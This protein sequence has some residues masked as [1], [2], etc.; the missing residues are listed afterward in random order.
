MIRADAFIPRLCKL[1]QQQDY[2]LKRSLNLFIDNIV[3]HHVYVPSN[4]E[5]FAQELLTSPDHYIN[6]AYYVAREMLGNRTRSYSYATDFSGQIE[7]VD[8]SMLQQFIEQFRTG[9]SNAQRV[10]PDTIRL[11]CPAQAMVLMM[12]QVHRGLQEPEFYLALDPSLEPLA[13]AQMIYHS[14]MHWRD[15][16]PDDPTFFGISPLQ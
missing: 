10:D 4:D 14:M 5:L 12:T 2:V 6:A 1:A 8:F 9:L 11:P 3:T 13:G 16:A 15:T 7:P